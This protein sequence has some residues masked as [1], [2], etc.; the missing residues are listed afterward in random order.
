M[1]FKSFCFRLKIAYKAFKLEINDRANYLNID[2]NIIENLVNDISL[3]IK[4]KPSLKKC[5][6]KLK[7]I[8]N[9]TTST[10]LRK[11][12]AKLIRYCTVSNKIKTRKKS[13]QL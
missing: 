12:I 2:K 8:K 1:L 11:E 5:N 10:I 7:E 13:L 4:E 9:K 6:E 3:I